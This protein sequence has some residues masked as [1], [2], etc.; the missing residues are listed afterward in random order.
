MRQLFSLA[1]MGLSSLLR[2]LVS[3][4]QGAPQRV[5]PKGK[6]RKHPS[7]AWRRKYGRPMPN[8]RPAL[9]HTVK[10]G[11]SAFIYPCNQ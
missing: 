4:P 6:A 8:C 10:R 2:S 7:K 3:L 5:A 1:S 11:T 9:H